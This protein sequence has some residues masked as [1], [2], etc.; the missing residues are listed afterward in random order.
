M[1]NLKLDHRTCH[2]MSKMWQRCEKD[3]KRSRIS[4]VV[5]DSLLV[6]LLL[7]RGGT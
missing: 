5:Q 1:L 3:A 7:V 6:S 4:R 2:R